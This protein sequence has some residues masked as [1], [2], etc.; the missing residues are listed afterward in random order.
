[1]NQ[2]IIQVNAE[3]QRLLG[4]VCDSALKQAGL[5][6]F[7]DVSAILGNVKLFAPPQNKPEPEEKPKK[8]DKK[9]K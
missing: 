2:I 1:M 8:G 4:N 3:G 7:N 9:E 6:A 5:N